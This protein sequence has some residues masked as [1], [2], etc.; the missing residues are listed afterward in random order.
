[1]VILAAEGAD[2]ETTFMGIAYTAGD[3]TVSYA[4]STSQTKAV[5]DY[6]RWCEKELESLQVAYTM[7]AM[8]IAAAMSETTGESA[9]TDKYEENTLSINFAF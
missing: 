7:G 4:E 6:S 5:S 8:T 3:V 1:M 9:A 2:V